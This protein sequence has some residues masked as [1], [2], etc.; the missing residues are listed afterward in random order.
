[1]TINYM[2]NIK[3]INMLIHGCELFFFLYKHI[4]GIDKEC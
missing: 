2:H 3:N 4:K 1:M